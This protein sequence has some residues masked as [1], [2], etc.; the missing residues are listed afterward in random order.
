M[1]VSSHSQRGSRAGFTLVEL[2]VVIGIIALLI[3]I[4]LPALNKA[5]ESARR[6]ACISNL[7]QIA[8][9]TIMYTGDN[10]GLM[11]GRGGKNNDSTFPNS[12]FVQGTSKTWD[13]IS[14]QRKVDPVTGANSSASD[15]N[16]TNSALSKYLGVK[17]IVTN[18]AEEANRTALNLQAV[19]RCPSDN[20]AQRPNADANNTYRYSYSMNDYISNPN[21][22]GTNDRFGW[23]WS[24]KI[25]SVRPAA[26]FLMYVC[27]DENT[28][29]DGV[30]RGST[31]SWVN[32]AGVNAVA[33]RHDLK[34][35]KI[36]GSGFTAE[37]VN[38]D[39][40][41]NVVFCDGHT[42]FMSRRDALRQKYTGN[43]TA[44]DPAFK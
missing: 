34:H 5:R 11:P 44:D 43:P 25:T 2:L 8:L 37:G 22:M 26:Q 39:A 13:W 14:W 35:K 33:A 30:Y 36:V 27:E 10:K 38:Q 6:V 4:L 24:G 15:T 31:T 23:H 7:H 16:I 32:N 40:F 9:A 41:G 19:F 17:E 28:I 1:K 42:D 12:A 21:K 29:D 3:G 20:L 18:S